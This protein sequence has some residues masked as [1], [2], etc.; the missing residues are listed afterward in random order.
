MVCFHTGVIKS[1][2]PQQVGTG[3]IFIFIK[4]RDTTICGS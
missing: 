2:L 1:L 4:K 3:F